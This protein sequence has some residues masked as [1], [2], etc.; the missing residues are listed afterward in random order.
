M[1]PEGWRKGARYCT[2]NVGDNDVLRLAA[3][4]VSLSFGQP[5]TGGGATPLPSPC[6]SGCVAWSINILCLYTWRWVGKPPVWG[7]VEVIGHV[8]VMPSR[9]YTPTTHDCS[10]GKKLKK[11]LFVLLGR[12]FFEW[13]QYYLT[14]KKIWLGRKLFR[15]GE[16]YFG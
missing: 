1:D 10:G 13:G 8:S 11:A 14:E 7:D 16:N 15:W 3:N 9:Q 4:L 12:K 5:K 2:I 6:G